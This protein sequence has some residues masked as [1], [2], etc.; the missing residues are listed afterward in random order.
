MRIHVEA[1]FR[2]GDS[3]PIEHRN[4][5]RAGL[6]LVHAAMGDQNFGHLPADPQVRIERRHGV[7]EYHGNAAAA[8]AVELVRRCAYELGAAEA[9]TAGGAAVRRQ[10]PHH[11]QERLALAGP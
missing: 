9:G 11:G 10:K 6:A 8:D 4:C 2:L 7:L 3:H 5:R 1:A